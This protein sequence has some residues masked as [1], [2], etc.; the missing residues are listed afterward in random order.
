MKDSTGFQKV[1]GK[2]L[3]PPIL[4]RSTCS[5]KDIPVE[6]VDLIDLIC[7]GKS[8]TF[9]CLMMDIPQGKDH[10]ER[11]RLILGRLFSLIKS[12]DLRALI[13]SHKIEIE[14]ILRKQFP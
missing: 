3:K 4:K 7:S 8:L 14:L 5:D 13:M 6:V 12:A 10:V 2:G 9:L 1:P 11:H